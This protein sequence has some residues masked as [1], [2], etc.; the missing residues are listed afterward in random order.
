VA[1]SGG[2]ALVL[3]CLLCGASNYRLGAR[4]PAVVHGIQRF[5][6]H[7]PTTRGKSALKGTSRLAWMASAS[8]RL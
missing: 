3:C 2:L 5:S 6:T 7:L 8:K 1:W 4:F